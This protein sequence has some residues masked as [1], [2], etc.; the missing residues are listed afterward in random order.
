MQRKRNKVHQ[1]K[2]EGYDRILAFSTNEK[3][4]KGKKS[5][6]LKIEEGCNVPI[7]IT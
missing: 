1:S 4:R 6:K 5:G 7:P 2:I 3:K